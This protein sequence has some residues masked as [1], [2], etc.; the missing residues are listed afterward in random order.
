MDLSNIIRKSIN[1]KDLIKIN[2]VPT[3]SSSLVIYNVAI[4]K[5]NKVLMGGTV[6]KDLTSVRFDCRSYY[7]FSEHFNCTKNIQLDVVIKVVKLV[8]AS[9]MEK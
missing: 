2:V 6:N 1:V 3:N 5:D 8:K 4:N 9:I 7:N